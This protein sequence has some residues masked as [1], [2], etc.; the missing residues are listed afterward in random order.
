MT[1]MPGDLDEISRVLGRLEGAV[2]QVNQNCNALFKKCDGMNEDIVEQRGAIKVLATQMTEQ[3]T[4]HG[5]LV[6]VIEKDIKPAIKEF[7][8]LKNQ[9]KGALFGVSLV[10]GGFGAGITAILTRMLGNGLPPTG[11]GG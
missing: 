2:A 6:A 9:G 7:E 11:H 3:N 4:K 5:E 1:N 10:S 8:S